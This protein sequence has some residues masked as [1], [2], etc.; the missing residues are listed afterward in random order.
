MSV[1]CPHA[2]RCGGCP[3]IHLDYHAGLA[4]KQERARRAFSRYPS[5]ALEPRAV[6]PA[7][8]VVDY[9]V[10]AKFVV[11][12]GA[13]VGLYAAASHEVV[14]IPE[15]RV[16]TPTVRAVVAALRSRAA[17]PSPADA[18][19]F[20]ALV[21]ID[22]REVSDGGAPRALLTLVLDAAREVPERALAAAAAALMSAAP[23]LAGVSV[24]RRARDAVQLLGAGHR[25]VRGVG[26]APDRIGEVT[27]LAVPGAFVQAHRAQAAALH[28]ALV[29][30]LERAL[31]GLAGKRGVELYAGSGAIG[32]ALAHAGM[33]MTLV[34]SYPEAAAA[35]RD[36]ARELPSGAV[37]VITGDAGR[38]ARALARDRVRP[39]VVVVDPPRRGLEP[40]ARV[41]LAALEPRALAY[42]SCNPETLARDLSHL[43]E[44]G[45]RAA[46]PEPFDMIPLT[47]ELECLA[48]LTR[49]APPPL[50]VLHADDQ[51]LVVDKPPHEDPRHLLQRVRRVVGFAEARAAVSLHTEAS[52]ALPFTHSTA[53]S[54][55]RVRFVAAV[56][57]VT[58]PSGSV[59]RPL[60]GAPARTRY[61][62]LGVAHGH[63]LLEILA[64]PGSPEQLRR[65]LAGL[66]HPV[67]GDTRFGH[68]PTNRHVA[69][70]HGLDRLFLHASRVELDP[71]GHGNEIVV[72]CAL[73]GDLAVFAE[74]SG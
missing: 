19:V 42:V 67:L 51:W 7:P 44:L 13:Q 10:R 60:G 59:N 31:G 54:A 69:E 5:L 68:G 72:S 45:Y 64:E 61:R 40:A 73:P 38:V 16:L 57:G 52:G 11:G 30:A 23:E 36:A 34:E 14:D 1:N 15:C 28:A 4:E 8:T 21:A 47:E 65:H 70:R 17:E 18:A 2:E 26:R 27:H 74:A 63:S 48:V 9:R 46:P 53:P 39:D 6:R 41:A 58:R 35:A 33:T 71:G 24:S 3:L 62:R 12:P 50:R 43:V 29:A 66:G 20:D 37:E 22:A 56:R 49:G 32:L 25:L 55:V